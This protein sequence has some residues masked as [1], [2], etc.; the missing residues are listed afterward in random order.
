MAEV[1]PIGTGATYAD[2]VAAAARFRGL[3]EG[4]RAGSLAEAALR[5]ALGLPHA[6][7]V[8]VGVSTPEQ[9]EDAIAAAERGPLPPEAM[10]EIARVQATLRAG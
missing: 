2:D 3:V 5:F 6:S 7:T 4:G 1:A 10:A 9:L 8:L